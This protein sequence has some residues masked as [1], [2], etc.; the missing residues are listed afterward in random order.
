MTHTHYMCTAAGNVSRQA[1]TSVS[2]YRANGLVPRTPVYAPSEVH[3]RNPTSNNSVQEQERAVRSLVFLTACPGV[4]LTT[5]LALCASH[6]QKRGHQCALLD[7]D[8]EAGGMDVLLGLES[9]PGLRLNDIE[10]PLGRI[11]AAALD[12]E[13][14]K[15]EGM[16]VLS[17]DPWK[18]DPPQWWDIEAALKALSQSN[19]IV[20]IDGGRGQCIEQLELLE[21]QPCVLLVELSILGLA[22]TQSFLMNMAESKVNS[23]TSQGPVRDFSYWKRCMQEKVHVVAVDPRGLRGSPPVSR[24]EAEDFLECKIV[25]S[26]KPQQQL[27]SDLLRG[28]GVRRLPRAYRKSIAELC[29]QIEEWVALDHAIRPKS[30]GFWG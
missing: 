26:F 23:S 7:L 18:G 17:C 29:Y 20:L 13:V 28:L 11:D 8:L 30:I 25:A 5:S 10:A 24:I 16:N 15:W 4:G 3:K 22:R 19:D 9:D 27:T 12:H 1:Q 21:D 6:L 2:K 14:L